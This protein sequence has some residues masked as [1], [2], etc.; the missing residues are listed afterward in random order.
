MVRYMYLERLRFLLDKEAVD[1]SGSVKD[2]DHIDSVPMWQAEDEVLI[3]SGH[4]KSAQSIQPRDCRIVACPALWML[5]QVKARV[6]GGGDVAFSGFHICLLTEVNE[7]LQEIKTRPWS[8]RD[9]RAHFLSEA[10]LRDSNLARA[11]FLRSVQNLASTGMGSP[12]L[13]PSSKS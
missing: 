9:R 6:I 2:A 12:E 5:H 1:V 4:R 11:S 13:R 10:F 3:K 7:L 8:L